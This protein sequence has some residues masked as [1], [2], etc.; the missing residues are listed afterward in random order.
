MLYVHIRDKVQCG[1][2]L[3]ICQNGKCLKAFTSNLLKH[4][5]SFMKVNI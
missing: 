2:Y 5:V 4:P 3:A 1:G